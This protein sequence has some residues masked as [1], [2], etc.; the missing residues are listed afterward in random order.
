M[1]QA[2]YNEYNP[3]IGLL[4]TSLYDEYYQPWHFIEMATVFVVIAGILA[5]LGTVCLVWWLIKRKTEA[6]IVTKIF[7][8]AIFLTVLVSYYLFCFEFP[9][10]CTENIRYCIPVIPILAMAL[11]LGVN[12]V[13]KRLAK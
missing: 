13:K 10:V 8:V 5:L 2:P 11:G 7:F 3:L 1:H 9:Y 6:D 12:E 4:K